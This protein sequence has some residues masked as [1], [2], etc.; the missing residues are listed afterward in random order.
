MKRLTNEIDKNVKELK[1]GLS[2]MAAVSC[3]LPVVGII[4]SLYMMSLY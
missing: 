1:K 2:L 4:F 3:I